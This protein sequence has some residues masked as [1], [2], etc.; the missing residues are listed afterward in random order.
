MKK[1]ILIWKIL[2]A[3][4]LL[5]IVSSY[6]LSRWTGSELSLIVAGSVLSLVSGAGCICAKYFDK[7]EKDT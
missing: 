4:G 1:E 2:F 3:V 7:N 6:N 5:V